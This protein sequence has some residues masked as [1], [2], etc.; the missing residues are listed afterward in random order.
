MKKEKRWAFRYIPCRTDGEAYREAHSSYYAENIYLQHLRYFRNNKKVYRFSYQLA[1]PTFLFS[2][3]DKGFDCFE[4]FLADYMFD[5]ASILFRHSGVNIERVHEEIRNGFMSFV[6]AF[7]F[8][9]SRFRQIDVTVAVH[10]DQ[11][12]VF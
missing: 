11:I 2:R 9:F 3:S 7:R 12:R 10:G 1:K 5:A 4:G 8:H 6:D